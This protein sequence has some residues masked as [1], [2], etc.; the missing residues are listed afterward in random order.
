M[1]DDKE[2]PTFPV[3]TEGGLKEVRKKIRKEERCVRGTG[4]GRVVKWERKARVSYV[5]N[6]TN[7]G[8]LL[9]WQYKLDDTRN[10]SCRFCRNYMETGKN[11]ALVCPYR[12]EIE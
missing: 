1:G 5:H 10:F 9:S 8:N 4:E 11:I 2:D 6:R 12:E 3:I 7:K